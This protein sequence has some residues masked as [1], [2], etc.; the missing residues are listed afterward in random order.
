MDIQVVLVIY[1]IFTGEWEIWTQ[2]NLD[3]IISSTCASFHEELVGQCQL[4]VNWYVVW[5]G[6]LGFWGYPEVTI[7]FIGESQESKPPINH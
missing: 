4:V 5:V 2:I 3:H 1:E 7:P 6:G